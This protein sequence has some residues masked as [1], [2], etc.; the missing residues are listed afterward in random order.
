MYKK[1]LVAVIF[2]ALVFSSL[3]SAQID[4]VAIYNENV[5]WTTVEVAAAAT[6]IILDTVTKAND[7]AVY[8]NAGM[9]DFAK[10]NTGDG[11][12]DVIV[13]FG[14]VPTTIYTP[15]NVEDDGSLFE[16]F[17]EGGDVILNT[18]DY[19]FY[20]TEGGGA[21]GDVGLK[22]M[23]DSNLDCWTADIT[24][25]PTADGE[26]YTPSYVSHNAPRSFKISQVADDPD[27]ELEV[28]FGT[29]GADQA[30]PAIIRN[31]TYGGRVGVVLQ[32][33]DD[34]M[35]K[36][37]VLGEIIE[38]YLPGNISAVEPGEKLAVT[39]GGIK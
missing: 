14:W 31:L 30:D 15:G 17:L 20:V 38:N 34:A 19:I 3:S 11:N 33:S 23:T 4:K 12:V 25:T 5:G 7:V 39:W 21:N 22:T 10:A 37:E 28:I 18:A 26:K 27:W 35:P 29:D 8:D 24:N 13:L 6:D 9:E 1:H 2:V 16:L 32:V 36:G